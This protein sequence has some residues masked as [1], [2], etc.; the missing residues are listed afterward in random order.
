MLRDVN[1]LLDIKK[2]RHP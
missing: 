2:Y 1:G